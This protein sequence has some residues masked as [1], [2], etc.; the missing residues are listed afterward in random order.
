MDG[1][2][3]SYPLVTNKTKSNLEYYTFGRKNWNPSNVNDDWGT[4][5]RKDYHVDLE[6]PLYLQDGILLNQRQEYWENYM[7]DRP[8]KYCELEIINTQGAIE[9]RG[10]VFE[11]T[12]DQRQDRTQV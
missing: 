8:G 4:S 3:R 1:V 10:V 12:E 7:I 9:V 2:G 11:D 5:G 6:V